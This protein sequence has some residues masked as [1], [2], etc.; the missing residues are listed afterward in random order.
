MAV[1]IDLPD[2]EARRRLLELYG[3]SVPLRLSDAETREIVER[4]DGVT[5]PFLK[6]LLRRAVLESLRE[7]DAEPVVTGAHTAR[8]LDDLLD[9]AEG[10]AGY[11]HARAAM[12]RH[13]R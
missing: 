9:G 4:T 11:A 10:W 1:E 7:N 13:G 2:A 12:F 3:R 6:E 8:A 5:A